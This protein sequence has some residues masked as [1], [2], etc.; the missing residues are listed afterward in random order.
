MLFSVFL[1]SCNTENVVDDDGSGDGNNDGGKKEELVITKFVGKNGDVS[2]EGVIDDENKSIKLLVPSDFDIKRV[3]VEVQYTDGATLNPESGYAYNF[4]QPI[5]F[6]LSKDGLESVKYKVTVST[7]PDILSFEVK[8]YNLFAKIEG[9][10]IKIEFPYGTDLSNIIPVIRVSQGCTIE[11]ES[12]TSVDMTGPIK[13]KV[14]NSS[15]D[16]K[17]YDIE[18]VVLPQERQ[19]RGVW[20]PDPTHTQVLHNYENLTEFVELL[21]ELNFNA[22]FLATWV[23]EQTLFKSEA[24]KENS[25]YATVEDGWLL[26]GTNYTSSTNDPIKDLITL[27]HKKNIKVF[28]WFEYGF[29]RS[30]GANPDKTNHPILSK[31]PDWDGINSYGTASNYN[32]TDYYLNSYDPE[33]QNFIISLFK[34]SLKLYPD[35][36]G[37]QGDD[38]LPAAPRNSGYNQIT[39]D[40]YKSETGKDVPDNYND[41]AWVRWRLDKLNAFGKRLYDEVKAVNSKYLVSFSPNP[42]PWCEQNLMQ[43]WPN[44]IKDGFVDFLSVQCYRDNEAGYR[45]TVDEAKKYVEQN[46]DKNI[47]N[48][49]IYLR[50]GNNWEE[51]FKA[52][53][54]IN[55]ELGTNG[56]A[57]FFNEGL[58]NEVNKKV[59]KSFYTGK[60]IF[61]F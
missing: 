5:E 44:W 43:D 42:Y 39:K 60:A 55:R 18:A 31:H 11:P 41:A 56:E 40:Q 19:I 10:K 33:V 35:V 1:L 22:I 30:G 59:I 14:T 15:G 17:E 9:E 52:Q 20:V 28:F 54:M 7:S 6:T 45:Y 24:L 8:A 57:F 50:T 27:A 4:T 16:V 3:N 25:N 61:P 12:E 37:V 53:M 46:T 2:V 21:D 26:R 51:L 32:G 47:L 23:R 29:M 13:Y 58:R 49:G 38:R 36:D 48:P 34:E